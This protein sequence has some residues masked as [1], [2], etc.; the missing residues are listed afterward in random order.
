MESIGIGDELRF[1]EDPIFLEEELLRRYQHSEDLLK[2]KVGLSFM[3]DAHEGQNRAHGGPYIVHP[4][5]VTLDIIQNHG[6]DLNRT[7]SSLLHDVVE[8]N[9]EISLD[10]I[11]L[12]FG[13]EVA[14]SVNLLSKSVGGIIKE[15]SIYEEDLINAPEYVK[16]IKVYDRIDNLYSWTR[17]MGKH[18][19]RQAKLEDTER[20]IL[21]LA[22]NPIAHANLL[23]ATHA[24]RLSFSS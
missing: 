2:V 24:V 8:D 21:P 6:L 20:T 16:L 10:E 1:S 22:T 9:P 7:I 13:Q 11:N 5:R 3:K 19:R 14:N 15:R 12:R 18:D 23:R 4:L 17:E